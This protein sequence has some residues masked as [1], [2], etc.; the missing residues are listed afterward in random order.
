[1]TSLQLGLQLGDLKD[2]VVS[3]HPSH[4]NIIM[5]IRQTFSA[6]PTSDEVLKKVEKSILKEAKSE[7]KN[8]KHLVKDLAATETAAQKA[9]K[10]SHLH[11]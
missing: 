11:P 9:L 3:L 8:L 5:G 7:E 2:A 6:Q 1:M 10:V 4:S